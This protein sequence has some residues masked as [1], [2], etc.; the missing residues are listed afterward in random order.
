MAGDKYSQK[1]DKILI[2][3]GGKE[4][5]DTVDYCTTRLRI[6]VHDDSVIDE[7][8]IK[9]SGAHGVVKPGKNNV[10]VVVGTEVEHVA[11]EMKRML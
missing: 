7:R 1:A 2:G 5:I 8:Q 10:Q 4:N 3:L 11:E 6:N 9:T